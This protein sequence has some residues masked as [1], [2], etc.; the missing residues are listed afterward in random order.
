[1]IPLRSEEGLRDE[2]NSVVYFL[3]NSLSR[4]KMEPQRNI[5]GKV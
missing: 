1:M 5:K 3:Q 2:D 4:K